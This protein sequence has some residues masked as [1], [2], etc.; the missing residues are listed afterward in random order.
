MT[1][2]PKI[3]NYLAPSCLND[4]EDQYSDFADSLEHTR[5]INAEK[6]TGLEAKI[7]KGST[8]YFA[9]LDAL[10]EFGPKSG[11]SKN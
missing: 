9:A 2:T 3:Q 4:L 10:R 5:Q 11:K 6:L 7:K 1:L 8:E